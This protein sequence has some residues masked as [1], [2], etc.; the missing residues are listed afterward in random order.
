MKKRWALRLAGLA[1][2]AVNG[3][4]GGGGGMVLLPL[5]DRCGVEERR[6]FASSVA[7][8]LPLCAL[9]AAVYRARGGLSLSLAWPYLAGGL[10]G[11]FL[12]GRLFR[13]VPV[14]WLRRLLAVFLLWAGIRY[15]R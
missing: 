4:F 9:S 12:G 15:L 7:V 2:G 3:F 10:V 11:G 14:D 6:A 1:A 13:R 5:L 8:M